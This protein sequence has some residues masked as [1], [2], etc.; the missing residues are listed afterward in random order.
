V[1]AE[2]VVPPE[3]DVER[4]WWA[5]WRDS[6]PRPYYIVPSADYVVVC[7]VVAG[8][9]F[10]VSDPR[11]TWVEPVTTPAEVAELRA[12]VYDLTMHLQEETLAHQVARNRA[13]V[14]EASVAALQ[15]QLDEI[16]PHLDAARLF[17]A[18]DGA[19]VPTTIAERGADPGGGDGR[20]A[21]PPAHRRGDPEVRARP[22][23]LRE[24]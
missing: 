14:A 18:A 20:A 12:R 2:R 19:E 15:S 16:A 6:A 9:P 24:G 3:A 23:T 17:T 4:W 11:W 5:I 7:G 21:A 1:T 13:K 10:P 8:V 22:T